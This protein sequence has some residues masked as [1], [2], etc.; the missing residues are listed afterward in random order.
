MKTFDSFYQLD[1]SL[2]RKY[3]GAGIGLNICKRITED[4]GGRLWIESIEGAGTKVH[5]SLPET[6]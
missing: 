3:G 5:V 2:T 6:S 1:G 4:H